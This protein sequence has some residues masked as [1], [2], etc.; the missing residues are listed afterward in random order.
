[1]RL[2]TVRP[3][4]KNLLASFLSLGLCFLVIELAYRFFDPFPYFSPQEINATNHGNLSQ[5]DPDLGWSGVPDGEAVFVTKNNRTHLKHNSQ[6]FRDIEHPENSG[7]A[8]IVFLGDS[9][10]FQSA[11]PK[12]RP[13]FGRTI[14]LY[15]NDNSL[16]DAEA[17]T[18]TF[19]FS[20]YLLS[21][22]IFLFPLV[23]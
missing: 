1:M 3:I 22:V 20:L 16:F 13:S 19:D 4:Y 18:F 12:A 7:K 15:I 17:N 21:L 9:F 5:Y 2:S 14:E 8:A 10:A 6:G 23:K 11:I